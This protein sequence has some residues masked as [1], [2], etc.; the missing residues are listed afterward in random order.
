MSLHLSLE[1]QSEA[2]SHGCRRAL[3]GYDLHGTLVFLCVYVY[4]AY[5]HCIDGSAVVGHNVLV[6]IW[7]SDM[8]F[9][10]S[11]IMFFAVDVRLC[12]RLNFALIFLRLFYFFSISSSGMEHSEISLWLCA[13]IRNLFVFELQFDSLWHNGRSS[14]IR[15]GYEISFAEG[16][17]FVYIEPYCVH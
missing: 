6:P 8:I 4:R 2:H 13:W 10:G 7:C 1:E 17:S 16:K 5:L 9:F 14:L 3:Q 12:S 15:F 11:D